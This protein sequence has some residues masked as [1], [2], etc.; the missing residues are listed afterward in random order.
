MSEELK[1]V[2]TEIVFEDDKVRV[3]NQVV[4]A[5]GEIPKHR[6]D[7]DYFLLNVSGTGPITVQFHDGSGADLGEEITFSPEPGTSNYIKK[8]HIETAQNKGD[9][10][11]AILV[12]LKD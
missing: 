12:E 4:P 8:G 5:G 1:P 6:H 2:A 10:Y 7:H 9:E 3:W 11:R